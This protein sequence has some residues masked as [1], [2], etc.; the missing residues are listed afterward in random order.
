VA[1]AATALLVVTGSGLVAFAQGG[2]GA[3]KGPIFLPAGTPLYLEVRLDMPDGQKEA[4]AQ[5]LTAFPGFADAGSFDMILEQAL[6]GVVGGMGDGSMSFAEDIGPWLSGEIGLGVMNLAT[7]SSGMSEV[8]ILLGAA[9][10]DK[11][12]ADAFVSEMLAAD[13]SD[14]I[15]EETYN[16]VSILVNE[17]ESALAVTDTFVLLGS[18]VDLVKQGLDVLAGDAP[19]MAEDPGFAEAFAKVPTAH[20]GAAYI[21]MQALLPLVQSGIAMQGTLP[22]GTLESALEMVPDSVT[23]YVAAA[24]DN[25]TV[26]V[27]TSPVEGAPILPESESDL[28]T[29]FPAGTHLYFETRALGETVQTSLEALLS[30]MSEEEQQ[31]LAPFEDLLGSSL[32]GVLDFVSDAAVGA[33][34][35]DG[36][37]SLGIVGAVGDEDAAALRVDRL[38]SVVN[39]LAAG[40]DSGIT[41]KESTVEGVTVTTVTLPREEALS[42][43]PLQVPGTL[44]V[45]VADGHLLLGLGDFVTEALALD[46]ADSLAADPGYS[47]AIGE[48]PNAGVFFSEIGELVATVGSIPGISDPD[49][50][51]SLEPMVEPLDRLAVVASTADGALSIRMSLYVD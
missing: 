21:D 3:T 2:A 43:I 41:V 16:D 22:P 17:D 8:D 18:S 27:F 28:A 7:S 12:A 13:G 10:G 47:A 34:L 39:L 45:A 49:Q 4:L 6:N 40:E 51:A 5:M 44:S 37:L 19:S 11:A 25:L 26:E 38:L 35:D 24:P 29:L 36:S 30:A 9:V 50:W 15:V 23:A 1:L 48:G 42:G 20:L 33:T 46:P 32:P 14:G 31:S